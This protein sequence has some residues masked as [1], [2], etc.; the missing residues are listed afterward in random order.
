ML[1]WNTYGMYLI[2]AICFSSCAPIGSLYHNVYIFDHHTSYPLYVFWWYF[3]SLI[4]LVMNRI[5]NML[6]IRIMSNKKT[7]WWAGNYHRSAGEN[8]L[9]QQLQGYVFDWLL[10]G[11]NSLFIKLNILHF[12]TSLDTFLIS[13]NPVSTVTEFNV[14]A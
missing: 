5:C 13:S 1:K 10:S 3:I 14:I 7:Q 9:S 11:I 6:W 12:Q 8:F 4:W 2:I